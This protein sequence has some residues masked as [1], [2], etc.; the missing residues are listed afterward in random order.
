MAVAFVLLLIVVVVCSVALATDTR[1]RMAYT[2]Q[3]IDFQISL[4]EGFYHY[5][6]KVSPAYLVDGTG[7]DWAAIVVHR[8]PG[9]FREDQWFV[10]EQSTGSSI[11][12]PKTTSRE[13]AVEHAIAKIQQMGREAYEKALARTQ[14]KKGKSWQLKR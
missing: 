12:I 3:E 2:Y 8:L 1:T 11:E 9:R 4:K 10:S 14:T 7:L 5:Q 13:K 6:Q